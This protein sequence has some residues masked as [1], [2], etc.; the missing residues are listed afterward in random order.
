MELHLIILTIIVSFISSVRI[1][2]I[3]FTTRDNDQF[4]VFSNL[5]LFILKI[6]FTDFNNKI[7]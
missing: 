3:H 4:C 5:K 2:Y 1:I 7:K 6:D